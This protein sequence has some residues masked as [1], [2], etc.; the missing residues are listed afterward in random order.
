MKTE[1]STF[2][3]EDLVAQ[4]RTARDGVRNYQARNNMREMQVGEQAF[5]YYSVKDRVVMG[6]AEVVAP[7]H[8][9]PST[10]DTRWEC[11]DVAPVRLLRRPV[12]LDEIKADP[13]LAE[14]VLVKNSR[15]SVQPVTPGEW[16]RV[17]ALS[18]HD[19]R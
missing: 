10:E 7:A 16:Q 12:S 13:A 8:Q 4:G 5:I 9:D 19:P 18:E 3:W 2:S 11:V 1:P 15:L 6:I 17:L 14:M